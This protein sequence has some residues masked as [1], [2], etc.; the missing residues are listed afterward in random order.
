MTNFRLAALAAFFP[1]YA[2]ATEAPTTADRPQDIIVT[3]PP[4]STTIATTSSASKTSQTI[5]LT[6]QSVQV[7]PLQVLLDQNAITLTDAVRNVAGVSSDFGFN[8]STEPLLILRGFP[9]TS[10]T[11]QGSML[12][13]ATYYLDGTRVKGITVNIANVEAV[14]VIKGPN[15]VLFG[16]AEP[17]GLVNVRYR[18][19]T[20]KPT[21]DFEQTIGQYDLF[22][23]SAHGSGKLDSDG[24]VLAGLSAS[25]LTS[26]S[27]R[28]YIKE[29]L[30]SINASLAW[31]PSSETRIAFTFDY[32]DHRFRNDYGI[33]AV[34]A[35]PADVPISTAYN[36]APVLPRNVSQSYRVDISQGLSA[37]WKLKLRGV[38]VRADTRDVDVVP[39]RVDLLTGN[40]CFAA[41]G[42][43]CRYYYY[44]RP[45]GHYKLDQITADVTGSL[46]TGPISHKLA[47]GFEW[48]RDDRRGLSYLQQL[49]P[50]NVF[51]PVLGNTPPLSTDPALLLDTQNTQDRNQWTS[52]FGED[53]I[54]FG[55]G[56]H[57][58]VALRHDWT[59]AI[60]AAPGVAPNKVEFT[61]PRLGLVWEFAADH[62]FYGQ[63]Q[64]SLATNNGRLFDG[65]PLAPEK[66]RQ[67]E[68]GYKFQSANGKLTATL[69]AFDLVKTNRADYTL[70]PIIRTIGRARSRGI[71]IDLI[72]DLTP[73]LSVVG[74]YA[75][76][77][78]KVDEATLSNGL[79]LAN[80]P[81]HAASLSGRY[82]VIT[83]GLI[84]GGFYYQGA[85][86]GDIGNTF[87]LPGYVRFDA[88]T[89]Y[90]FIVGGAIATAQINLKNV[91]NK[92]YF[93]GSHQ[94]V[95][96]WIQ[97]GQPRT[98]SA[99]LRVEL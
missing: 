41:N 19:L 81:R 14:E 72:G 67:F 4:Y 40:D 37:D 28:D 74:A 63:F 96:D 25:Y 93:T 24:K 10:M 30:G 47:F 35:R 71:E 58:V 45:D 80:V 33:P 73:K 85:R 18:P 13:S 69:A 76:T 97:V 2:H 9:S 98:V 44:A 46:T 16:R 90:R 54:D 55:S 5:L 79:T 99:T 53:Q 86:Y 66:A 48:Y 29:R 87:T 32:S 36:D 83:N 21:F 42:E 65:T 52:V 3:A 15:S 17:G 34:G 57:A 75:Y 68:I 7:I 61:S 51:N 78:A 6:P 20:A 49:A 60:Y 23:T 59:S 95:Q 1:A 91:F 88:F 62:T 26:G 39:Y 56:I 82:A 70:F 84:G 64:R 11:A 38:H 43:L 89:A 92:R 12:G 31:L 22:R 77:D 8:G 94:F 27:Y 50:V